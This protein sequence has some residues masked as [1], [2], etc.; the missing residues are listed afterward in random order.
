MRDFITAKE[1]LHNPW[2][3]QIVNDVMW[4]M[5]SFGAIVMMIYQLLREVNYVN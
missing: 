3:K 5:F 4:T 2:R 1:R